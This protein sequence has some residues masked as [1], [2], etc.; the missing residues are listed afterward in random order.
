MDQKT[1]LH[2]WA[3]RYLA[4]GW[5]VLPAVNKHPIVPWKPFQE[6][7]VMIAQWDEWLKDETV[8]FDQIALVT[9][10]LSGVTVLDI[11]VPKTGSADYRDVE[12]VASQFRE[13]QPLES[14]TG[15]GGRHLFFAFEDI[16][17][18]VKVAHPQL[19]TR[20]EGGIIILPPSTHASGNPYEWREAEQVS[21]DVTLPAFPRLLKAGLLKRPAKEWGKLLKEGAPEGRRTDAL[22]AVIA[23][24]LHI[25]PELPEMA[26][27]VATVWNRKCKP[28]LPEDELQRTWSS[29]VLKDQSGRSPKP[30]SEM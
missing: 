14:R 1:V 23:K 19:D 25:A 21:E 28:P 9:G 26:L 12:W 2:A 15:G 13:G 27:D 8:N 5:N 10:R 18:S 29:M 22:V 7:R 16:P 3:M 4:M 11:D 6:R 24:F 20:S 17:N 30:M